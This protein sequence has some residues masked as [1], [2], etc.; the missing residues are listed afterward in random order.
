VAGAGVVAVAAIAA[1]ALLFLPA[2]S[3]GTPTAGQ[4]TGLA[5]IRSE[6]AVSSPAA[7]A[8]TPAAAP[9]GTSVPSAYLGRWQGTLADHIGLT[10]PEPVQLSITNGAVNSVVGSGYYANE[11]CTYS[12][13]LVAAQAD[14]VT[15]HELVKPGGNCV[16]DWVVLTPDG[17]GLTETRYSVSLSQGQADYSGPI[18]RAG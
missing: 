15:L 7:D 16:S 9:T 5:P 17:S 6:V 18:S 12:L 13:Q 14:K 1:G 11:G 10:G 3:S 8:A 2:G 4:P